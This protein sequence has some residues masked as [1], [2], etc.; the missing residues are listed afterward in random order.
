M[1]KQVSLC[2]SRTEYVDIDIDLEEEIA[3]LS[4][5]QLLRLRSLIDERLGDVGGE[6]TDSAESIFLAWRSGDRDRVF[7]LAGEYARNALGRVC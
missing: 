1:T 2:V 3:H 6:W 5:A 4:R 7:N